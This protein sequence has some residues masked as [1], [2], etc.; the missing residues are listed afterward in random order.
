MQYIRLTK[1]DGAKQQ[2]IFVRR[3]SVFWVQGAAPKAL[4]TPV[5]TEPAGSG[6]I[7]HFMGGP[8][9]TITVIESAADVVRKLEDEA[10]EG[11][12]KLPES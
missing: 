10:P 6:A 2:P 3:E 5:E 7:L 8:G 12:P 9:H 11:S 4:P 1:T